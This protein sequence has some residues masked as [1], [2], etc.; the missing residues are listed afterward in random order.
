MFSKKIFGE[1]IKEL[2][3][4]ANETQEKLSKLLGVTKTQISDL[5]NGKT[6]TTIEKLWILTDHFD[7]S[8]DYLTGRTENRKI[9]K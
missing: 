5:E 6:T 3:K 7:V 8:M 4:E 9:R 1:R 2:R